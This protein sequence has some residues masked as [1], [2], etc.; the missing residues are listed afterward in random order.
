MKQMAL[1]VLSHRVILGTRTRL[2]GRGS[3]TIVQEVLDSVA[4]PVEGLHSPQS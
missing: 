4:V 1:P 2:R 3:E